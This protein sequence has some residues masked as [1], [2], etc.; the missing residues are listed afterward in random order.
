MRNTICRIYAFKKHAFIW[1]YIILTQKF[2]LFTSFISLSA[3]SQ[4]IYNI[5]MRVLVTDEKKC[6]ILLNV[7]KH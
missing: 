1:R 4:T 6:F 5:E 2:I 3:Y 7:K